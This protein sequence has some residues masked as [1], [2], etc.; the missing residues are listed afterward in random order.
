MPTKRRKLGVRK[1][2]VLTMAQRIH[3]QCG[4][5]LLDF[6]GEAD[7]F[8]DDRH[9]RAAWAAH[10]DQI[11]ADWDRPGQRPAA[12]WAYDFGLKTP[13]LSEGVELAEADR[14]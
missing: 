9:R 3:L 1:I 2:S 14:D 8:E 13:P 4:T 10:R 6:R 7:R 12:M 5:Y 11:L